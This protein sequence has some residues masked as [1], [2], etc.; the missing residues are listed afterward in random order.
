MQPRKSMQHGGALRRESMDC[1]G[2]MEELSQKEKFYK[3]K[4]RNECSSD[5]KT[6]TYLHVCVYIYIHT[7][8]RSRKEGRTLYKRK[9]E[10][11]GK[12][13]WY[14]GQDKECQPLRLK[15]L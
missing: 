14:E 8:R 2:K 5:R 9:G 11:P 15:S 10:G 6:Y 4:Q 7:Q 12:S 3:A 13:L 1:S